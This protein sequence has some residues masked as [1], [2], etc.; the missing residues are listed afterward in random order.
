MN[1]LQTNRPL[2]IRAIDCTVMEPSKGKD[3]RIVYLIHTS[4]SATGDQRL[5]TVA[6]CLIQP[7]CHHYGV[8][9][10][11][12]IREETLSRIFL[13]SSAKSMTYKS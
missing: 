12:A 2:Q 11:I 13:N 1:H 4:S 3:D 7:W 9:D 6:F 10:N 8:P 5:S